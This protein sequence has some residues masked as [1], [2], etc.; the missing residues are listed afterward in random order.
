MINWKPPGKRRRRDVDPD[1]NGSKNFF[2]SGRKDKQGSN[3]YRIHESKGTKN[4]DKT[5]E[6]SGVKCITGK[7][8]PQ[9]K[10]SRQLPRSSGCHYTGCNKNMW[11]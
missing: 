8:P 6:K 4:M 5:V 2:K 7:D 9:K 10:G 1:P 3:H 11:T